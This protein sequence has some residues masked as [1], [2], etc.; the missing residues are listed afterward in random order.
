MYDVGAAG[1]LPTIKKSDPLQAQAACYQL[2][3]DDLVVASHLVD[4]LDHRESNTYRRPD[5]QHWVM[6][7]KQLL[8]FVSLCFQAEVVG[9]AGGVVDGR[10]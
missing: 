9:L 10:F 5:E 3:L 7:M 4:R 1:Q 2:A 8:D 6:A